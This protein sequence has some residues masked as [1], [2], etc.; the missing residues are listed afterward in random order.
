[1]QIEVMIVCLAMIAWL[2][3]CDFAPQTVD[4]IPIPKD[5]KPDRKP[6]DD[7]L[8]F[9][10]GGGSAPAPDPS[11]GAAALENAKLGKEWLEF[12]RE[13]FGEAN[14]RQDELDDIT[15]NVTNKQLDTQDKANLW[16][17]QDRKAGLEYR[18]RYSKYGQQQMDRY[19]ATFTSIEDKLAS[20]AANWDSEERMTEE[21]AK[22]KGTA[23]SNI[24]ASERA[25]AGNCHQW[26]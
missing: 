7:L 3:V 10:K 4:G 22:A 2:L 19:N 13:Q 26:G 14:V 11:I 21:A 17:D 12:A 24:Q 20:D 25:G 15:K 1:M 16:A 5:K 23:L 6:W 18:D 9:K 8:F